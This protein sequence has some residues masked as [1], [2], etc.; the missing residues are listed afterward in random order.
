MDPHLSI[1]EVQDLAAAAPNAARN[2]KGERDALIIQTIF[3]GCF[4]GSR[5]PSSSL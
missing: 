1:E 2:G 3:E 4:R 5:S